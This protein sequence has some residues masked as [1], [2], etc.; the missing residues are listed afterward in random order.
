MKTDLLH[1]YKRLSP[2]VLAVKLEPGLED[3]WIAVDEQGRELSRGS[4]EQAVRQ[5]V[6][7]ADYHPVVEFPGLEDRGLSF[8]D[9]IINDGDGTYWIMTEA[10]FEKAYVETDALDDDA[11]DKGEKKG[12]AASENTKAA[13][14]LIKVVGRMD[15]FIGRL[16]DAGQ[17][18]A[19]NRIGQVLRGE[20]EPKDVD[21][22][23]FVQPPATP[24]GETAST[25]G[26]TSGETPSTLPNTE[27]SS[28]ANGL[29]E[30]EQAKAKAEL[31][32]QAKAEQ[33]KAE[34]T[35]D[36]LD[37]DANGKKGGAK[38]PATAKKTT[39]AKA[40]PKA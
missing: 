36:P 22:A 16:R 27:G 38:K 39:T 7:H 1:P 29:Q 17:A 28:S 20:V 10:D 3:N 25:T 21:I 5:A 24:S 37:H 8:G 14:M 13:D 32:E 23:P 19:A 34:Q 11:D 35:K 6:P 9:Y 26:S 4:T 18:D 2:K 33:A 30:Q 31:A 12:K 40:A 15:D